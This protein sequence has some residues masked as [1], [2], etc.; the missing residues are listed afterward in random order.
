MIFL[1][2]NLIGIK[3]N[4]DHALSMIK[5]LGANLPKAPP[6]GNYAYG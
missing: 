1:G 4:R 6:I 3:A 5:R 2:I